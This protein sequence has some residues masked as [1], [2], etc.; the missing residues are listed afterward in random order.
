MHELALQR[1][2]WVPGCPYRGNACA[3]ECVRRTTATDTRVYRSTPP[4]YADAFLLTVRAGWRL[5]SL[6]LRP[7]RRVDLSSVDF[8]LTAPQMLSWRCAGSSL[9]EAWTA[10]PSRLVPN[11]DFQK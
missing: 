9:N 2:A 8:A 4:E 3:Y 10:N 11:R 5:G 6:D 7:R 1:D